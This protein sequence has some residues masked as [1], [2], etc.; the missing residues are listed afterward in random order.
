MKKNNKLKLFVH[1]HILS[2]VYIILEEL[3]ED[4]NKDHFSQWT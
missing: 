2:F 1:D 3:Q 4:V